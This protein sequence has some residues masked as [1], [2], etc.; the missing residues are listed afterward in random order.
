MTERRLDPFDAADRAEVLQEL[1]ASRIRA[2]QP[3]APQTRLD[4]LAGRLRDAR[5]RLIAV[6]LPMS[7]QAAMVRGDAAAAR[8]DET[9]G[10]VFG[11]FVRVEVDSYTDDATLHVDLDGLAA[12]EPG[13]SADAPVELLIV[14]GDADVVIEAVAFPRARGVHAIPLV[15]DGTVL[16]APRV[17]VALLAP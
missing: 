6:M 17:R 12:S 2:A 5:S 13:I 3:A 7:G 1:F 4:T 14:D 8:A 16:V 15:E 9:S 11:R 10:H